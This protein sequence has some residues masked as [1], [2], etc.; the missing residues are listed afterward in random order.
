MKKSIDGLLHKKIISDNS[1]TALTSKIKHN[2]NEGELIKK[3]EKS[4]KRADLINIK[5]SVLIKE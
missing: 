4:M 3:I 2:F 1:K 5:K